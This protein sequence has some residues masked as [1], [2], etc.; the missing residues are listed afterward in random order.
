MARARSIW[1]VRSKTG[2]NIEA[3]FTVKHECVGWLQRSGVEH[4]LD[5]TKIKD[6]IP[7]VFPNA[8]IWEDAINFVKKYLGIKV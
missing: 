5:V 3:A 6:G 4:L 8:L 1:L 2:Q 7:S